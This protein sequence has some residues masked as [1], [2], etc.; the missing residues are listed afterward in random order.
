MT[1]P[2]TPCE[3]TVIDPT[4]N[5]G[6]LVDAA[7]GRQDDLRQSDHNHMRETVRLQAS[8]EQ[9]MRDTVQAYQEKL[10]TAAATYQ[11]KLDGAES[12]RIDAIRQV[13]VSAVAAA[14]AVQETRA[15]TLAGQVA[16]SADAMRVQVAATAQ[17]S[18]EGL[19][20]ALSPLQA[21]I[22]ELRRA[23]YEAVGQKA[24]VIETRSAAEDM[25][26]L[27]D[28]IALLTK[29]QNAAQ[30]AS[31]NSELTWGRVLGALGILVVLYVASKSGIQ[32]N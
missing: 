27:V 11:E 20:R 10:D 29:A 3:H 25:K 26:P 31:S 22:D 6:N 2:T 13:D 18:Q 23:Q 19:T 17:A 5:V 14:A 32:V 16:L 24:Q 30:G 4:V 28:A 1:Q 7:V 8:F 21:A 12:K 9:K 15:N